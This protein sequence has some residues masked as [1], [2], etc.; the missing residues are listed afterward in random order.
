[1]AKALWVFGFVYKILVSIVNLRAV[2]TICW[3]WIF[4]VLFSN[5]YL[6]EVRIENEL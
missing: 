2:W 1:M 3:S 5:V 6:V 4:G